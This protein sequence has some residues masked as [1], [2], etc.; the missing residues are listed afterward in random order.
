M[1]YFNEVLQQIRSHEA[2]RNAAVAVDESLAQIVVHPVVLQMKGWIQNLA[3]WEVPWM[4]IALA[5]MLVAYCWETYLKSRQHQKLKDNQLPKTVA[6]FFKQA[7]FNKSRSYGLDK[8]SA[9]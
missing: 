3:D 9:V 4:Q 1:E 6:K 7:D 5:I 8:V 2:Y